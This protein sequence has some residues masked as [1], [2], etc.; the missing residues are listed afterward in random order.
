MNKLNQL[1]GLSMRAGK[2]ISGEELVLRAVRSRSAKL[3]IMSEDA[4]KNVEKKVTD[5]CHTYEIP[6]LRFG[7]RTD[8]GNAIGKGQR[9]VVALTDQGFAQSIKKL[10]D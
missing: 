4:A 10:F 9:V 6:L 2:L 3:V 1:L 5:K 8:I 7:T